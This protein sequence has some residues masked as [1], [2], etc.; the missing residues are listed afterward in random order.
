MKENQKKAPKVVY[1]NKKFFQYI[2]LAVF[3]ALLAVEVLV[4]VA[5]FNDEKL[6][7]IP[8]WIFILG[9]EGVFTVSN[10]FKTFVCKEF[11]HKIACYVLDFL[12]QLILTLL[13]SSDYLCIVYILILSEFYMSSGGLR[14]NIAMG[15]TS[16]VIYVATYALGAHSLNGLDIMEIVTKSFSELL[17]IALHFFIVNYALNVYDSRQRLAK[18]YEELNESNRKLQRAYDEL[19]KVTMLQERQRIAKDIHDTAGHSITTVIMQTEAA[20]LIVEEN[21]QEAKRKI[22]AANLQAKN[23]LEELR[24]SV[25]LLAGDT[26]NV[27][28]KSALERIIHDSCDGTD[29]I[30]RYDIEDIVCSPAKRRFICNSLKEGISNGLRHGHATAFYFE[31]RSVEDGLKFLLSDNGKGAD[32][33]TFKTGFGMRSMRS[34]A[35][36]FGGKVHFSAAPDEGFEIQMEL[37]ADENIQK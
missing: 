33:G 28:L 10:V 21:P 30:I 15:V 32:M 1:R 20:K 24:E 2:R 31:F 14:D 7:G 9:I 12:S 37:P 36:S 6:F 11:R 27:S 4:F 13:I 8:Q 19:A 3:V 26:E 29:L 22:V 16:L 34:R 18:S 25:H 35:E 23:A 17:I 5:N